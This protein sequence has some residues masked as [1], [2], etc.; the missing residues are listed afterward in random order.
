VSRGR[1]RLVILAVNGAVLLAAALAA[2]VAGLHFQRARH[3]VDV[4]LTVGTGPGTA[5]ARPGTPAPPPMQYLGVYVPTSPGNY[6]GMASFAS[7][8]GRRPNIAVY[9]SSWWEPFRLQFAQ[10]ARAHGAIPMVQVE[11]TR[12]AWPGSPLAAT[13]PT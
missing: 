8:T 10:S 5:T 1:R 6:S 9:Y 4:P 13:T 3:P 7:L 2:T 12:S 11:R